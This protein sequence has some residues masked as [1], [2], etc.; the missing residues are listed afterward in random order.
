MDITNSCIT[1]SPYQ[2]TSHSVCLNNVQLST[3]RKYPSI[4]NTSIIRHKNKQYLSP[5]LTKSNSIL[6]SFH[7]HHHHQDQDQDHDHYD[8]YDQYVPN[9][10]RPSLKLNEDNI[11]FVKRQNLS[12]IQRHL[13]EESIHNQSPSSS[14][15]S[16]SSSCSSSSVHDNDPYQMNHEQIIPKE[17]H[18]TTSTPFI[19]S[20]KGSYSHKGSIINSALIGAPRLALN[21]SL[22]NN[23]TTTN[24]NNNNNNI[25]DLD[26]PNISNTSFSYD[27]RNSNHSDND[28]DHDPNADHDPDDNHENDQNQLSNLINN[29]YLINNKVC[30]TSNVISDHINDPNFMT[31]RCRICLDES[32]NNNNHEEEGLLSPCRCKGTIGLVHKKCLQ[33]WLLTSGKLQCELCGYVYLMKPSKKYSSFHSIH[34]NQFRQYN[35]ELRQ[36]CHWLQWHRIRKHLI[37][38]IIC[39]ILLIPTTYIGVYFCAVSAFSYAEFNPFTWQVISLW[40]LAVLLILLLTIWI[41]LAI[42]HHLNHYR[43]YQHDQQQQLTL[44]E[45]N[46]L[47]RLPRYRFSIQPRPRGSSVV[48]YTTMIHKDQE[49]STRSNKHE[50]EISMNSNVENIEMNS[51][52]SQHDELPSS[53]KYSSN[54]NQKIVV[55]VE[56]TTVPEVMEELSTSNNKVSI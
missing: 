11:L 27:Q 38:D 55:S 33:K 40:G 7:H 17:I 4:K 45:T 30:H 53:N 14:S 15:S 19:K 42:K 54:G 5:K 13:H 37:V 22:Q 41:I 26:L 43:H 36:F 12:K 34:W 23:N 1:I 31:F 29:Q 32:Q 28:D 8:S 49:L 51:S 18:I 39:M 56:L 47:N 25:E 21:V 35:D 48:L 20:S 6:R 50:T 24:N 44:T 3:K 46:P 52:F 2:S 9:A 10:P 16:S